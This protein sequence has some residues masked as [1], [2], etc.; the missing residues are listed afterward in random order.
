MWSGVANANTHDQSCLSALIDSFPCY[1]VNVSC[2]FFTPQQPFSSGI[3][4]IG[5]FLQ[6]YDSKVLR[7]LHCRVVIIGDIKV[8]NVVARLL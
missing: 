5:Q 3:K 8:Q 4:L 1:S 7:G 2:L 6:S